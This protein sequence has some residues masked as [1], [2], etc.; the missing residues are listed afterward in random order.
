MFNTK[1]EGAVAA[2]ENEKRAYEQL[3]E[4][5]GEAIP[6]LR[7]SG[8]LAH[9]SAPVIV[10][11]WEGN[12][13]KEGKSVHRRLRR[14]MREALKALLAIGAAHGDVRLS[15]FVVEGRT[16][17]RLVDLGQTVV[18]ASEEVRKEEVLQ[19]EAILAA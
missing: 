12:A 14:P 3:G 18:H 5:Q 2:Y 6:Y 1:Q 16:V 19:L 13:L 15:N 4:L 10:T 11:S 9:T 8:L 7:R 17:V